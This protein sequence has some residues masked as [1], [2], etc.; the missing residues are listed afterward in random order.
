MNTYREITNLK[1]NY[2][3]YADYMIYTLQSMF[4]S[5]PKSLLNLHNK[6]DEF[7]ISEKINNLPIK[8]KQLKLSQSTLS[9]DI[10][11]NSDD[12]ESYKTISIIIGQDEHFISYVRKGNDSWY[13]FDAEKGGV[14]KKSLN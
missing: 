3:L 13:M 12:S 10:D 2:E 9:G 1:E 11:K 8:I 14:Q 5:L 4:T 6:N 7:K